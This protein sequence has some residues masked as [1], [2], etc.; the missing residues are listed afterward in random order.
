MASVTDFLAEG[1][2]IPEGSALKAMQSQTV[3]PEWYTNYAMQLL[4]NQ[5]AQAAQPYQTYQGPRIAEFS[6]LQ[7]RSFEMTKNV[8][9]SYK[10]ALSAATGAT[11]NLMGQTSVSNIGQYMNP[12]T[13]QVVEQIGNL[14]G[15]NLSE[16]IMPN[17][18]GRYVAAGQLGFGG[19]GGAAGTP[20]GMLTDTARAIR[21]TQEAALAEQSR[22]LQAGYGQAAELAGSDISR[23]MGAA[24][25]LADMGALTQQLGLQGAGALG[26]V[27][28]QQQQQA[29]GNLDLAY[30]DF[31]R[32]Q[33]YNQE[34]INNMLAT[35]QGV[36]GGVPKAAQEVGIEPL[37]YPQQY[38]PST[39]D[40]IG[41]AIGTI[42]AIG[43]EFG[44]F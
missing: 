15:R 31:L 9:P 33:G 44:W 21:D 22:A 35:F 5:Q 14:A 39:A 2:Q 10:P 16:N 42:G 1:T 36:A 29:Q 27:G 20:S 13:Q 19:R 12:Y 41:G 8:A 23:Q 24:G 38:A 43:K 18:E 34:Q 7:Q 30:Q 6:P 28:A 11:Q 37:G 17:I 25:Q 26:A 40:K 32:Q 3:L 4:A